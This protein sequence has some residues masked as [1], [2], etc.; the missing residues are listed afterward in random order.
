MVVGAACSPAELVLA[1]GWV[2][3]GWTGFVVAEICVGRR[4]AGLIGAADLVFA[5]CV[6]A[7][8]V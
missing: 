4:W 2:A 5:G 3:L 1:A 7:G 6:L 8:A